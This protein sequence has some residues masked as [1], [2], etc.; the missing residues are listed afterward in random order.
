METGSGKARNSSGRRTTV[1]V[2]LGPS[3]AIEKVNT[4]LAGIG[5]NP[6][7]Y[8]IAMEYLKMLKEVAQA[9]EGQKTVFMPY[10]SASVLGAIGGLK[11]MLGSVGRT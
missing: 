9:D 8:L 5:T 6:A 10:E 1:S 3:G 4:S 7:Q 11:E 2:Q